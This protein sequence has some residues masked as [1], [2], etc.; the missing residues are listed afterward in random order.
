MANG[1]PHTSDLR[2]LTSDLCLVELR[3]YSFRLPKPEERDPWFGGSETFWNELI[4]CDPPEVESFQLM[5]KSDVL[6]IRMIDYAS[7]RAWIE[8]S[9]KAWKR[10]KADKDRRLFDPE[11]A[12]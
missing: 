6:R 2:P 9:R 8:S 5:R 4:N 3:P 10:L 7:A 11:E 12:A 1:K